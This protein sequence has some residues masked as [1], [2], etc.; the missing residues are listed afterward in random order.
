MFNLKMNSA[1]FVSP[2][3]MDIFA[4]AS[5]FRCVRCVSI[6][7]RKWWWCAES[8][9]WQQF[10]GEMV[11]LQSQAAICV[12]PNVWCTY[13]HA[14][15]HAS[16]HTYIHAYVRTYIHTYTHTYIHTHIHTY[17]HTHIHTYTHTHIQ[18]YIHTYTHTY[19]HTQYVSP[20]GIS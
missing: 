15:M 5:W 19:I 8:V 18:T 17:T 6:A 4:E 20:R 3:W 12:C 10:T 11:Q 14:C 13:I 1:N 16:I 9:A 2:N 7:A